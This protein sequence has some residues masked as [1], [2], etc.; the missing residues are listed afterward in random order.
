[1]I[2]TTYLVTGMTCE[3]CVTAV[4]SEFRAVEGVSDVQVDLDPAGASSV[5]VTSSAPLTSAQVATALD[6]AGEYQLQA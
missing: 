2:T 3:H 5:H 1:M 4:S 6:E